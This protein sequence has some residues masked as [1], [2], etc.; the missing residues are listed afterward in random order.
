M[1][2]VVFL[3]RVPKYHILHWESCYPEQNFMIF[4]TALALRKCRKLKVFT[5]RI[6]RGVVGRTTK[7]EIDAPCDMQHS[8]GKMEGANGKT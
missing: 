1:L 3:C 4:R 6:L 5:N 7:D 8:G 2:W